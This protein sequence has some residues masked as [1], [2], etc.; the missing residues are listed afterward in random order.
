MNPIHVLHLEDSSLDAELIT[1]RLQRDEPRLEMTRAVGHDDYRGALDSRR[2]DLIL[3]D[4][5]LPGFDGLSAL[6]MARELAPDT[7]FLFVSGVLG[8][9]VAIETLKQG[10]TDYVLK[11]RLDRLAP[12]VRRALTEA[13]ERVDRRKAESALHERER[14]HRLTLDSVKD[15][16]ILTIDPA[17]QIATA[18]AGACNVLGYREGELI[19]RPTRILF[20]PEDDR[21]GIPRR[22]LTRAGAR[23]SGDDERWYVRK[24]GSHFWGSGLVTPLLDEGGQLRGYTK[25]VRDMSERK[26]TEEAFLEADRRKD[27]FLA[28]L[29]HELRNPLSAITNAARLSRQPGLPDD[30]AERARGVISNQVKHLSRL[31]DDLLDVSRIT[32]RKVRLRPDRVDLA[33]ILARA[34]ETTSAFFEERRHALGLDLGF[35][36]LMVEGD[37][38]RLEQVFANLLTNAGKYTEPGGRVDL[39]AAR[40]GDSLVIRVRDNGIGIGPEMLAK[41]FDLFAQVDRS[42]DRS[43][44]GLGIGLTIARRLVEMH[45]GTIEVSSEGNA[46]GSVFT[47]RLPA[48]KA[49]APSAEPPSPLPTRSERSIRPGCRILIVDDN[50]DSAGMLAELLKLSGFEVLK[51]H[52]GREAIAGARTLQPEI[53][54]L[55][56][57]LPGMDGYQVAA[58]LRGEAGLKD[59]TIIAITGYGEEQAQRRSREAGFDFHL[60]KPVNY[61]DL[62]ELLNSRTNPAAV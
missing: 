10:A 36:A 5:S 8:E 31:V 35:D 28:M 55:D 42:L 4:Y 13:R 16:A 48:A 23:G 60:V 57:G 59:L 41:V 58:H 40:E 51:A 61:D 62:L 44:G 50:Q 14:M 56:I 34:V 15:Y 45:G 30:Q 12:A 46:R 19:G 37:P 38:T 9:E 6:K 52:D 43:Q 27:E 20:T 17:G 39:S 21:A 29:A 18:S 1:K 33:T 7:P 22:E 47:V 25:V 2:F 32:L 54:L 53:V 49:S 24:D 11:H 26:R 3:A